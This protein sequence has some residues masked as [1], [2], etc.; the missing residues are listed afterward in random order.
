MKLVIHDLNK[1]E[2]NNIA[3]D[4]GECEVISDDGTINS[5]VGCFGCWLRTPGV[6]TLKDK[7]NHMGGLIHKADEVVIISRFTYGGFSGFVK[8]VMDRSIGYILPFFR[9]YKGE[10]HHKP[11][12]NESKTLRVIFRGDNLSENDKEKARK[13]VE[14][15]STNFN[16]NI[17]EIRFDEC[18]EYKT[19]CV[20]PA[21]ANSSVEGKTVFLNCSLRGDNSN[22]K[23]FLDILEEKT[24][25][26]VGRVNLSLYTK[27][28]DE[29]CDILLK[30]ERI[31][32]GMPLY[33]DGI[34]STPLRLMEMLEKENMSTGKK[35]YVVANMGF[36][37]SKQIS[38]LLA[39][40]KSWCDKC[41]FEY[42]GGIAIGAGEMMGQVLQF[43]SKGPAKNV[44]SGLEELAKAIDKSAAIGDI[45]ADAYHFPR[46]LYFMAAN[47]GMKKSSKI[48][49]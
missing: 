12:Y 37:E 10:M 33:V 35:I 16:A 47:S 31:V 38:N 11:R 34:P 36:Y 19:E 17:K 2:W 6:C 18:G 21:S 8:N 7:Y 9:I 26:G 43:G 15:V 29:L 14:A 13:Y 20:R 27:K 22:S 5:C 41:G 39:M 25:G 40:V 1:E 23:K 32:L 45:Y 24:K 30:A 48:G 4:Y 44:F 3:A 46:F 42:C 28:L 49:K